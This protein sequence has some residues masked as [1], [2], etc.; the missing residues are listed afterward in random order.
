MPAKAA[1]PHRGRR[2]DGRKTRLSECV[3]LIVQIGDHLSKQF[4]VS[5]LSGAPPFADMTVVRHYAVDCERMPRMNFVPEQVASALHQSWSSETARQWTEDNPAA[6]Q[7]NV[8]VL[9][10]HEL[11]GGE[12]LKTRLPE[13]D[14]FYNRIDGVRF[15]FTASQFAH[16]ITYADLPT[17]RD[18]AERGATNA[19]LA[20]LRT[21]FLRYASASDQG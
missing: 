10:V 18:D 19:E 21:A 11:F 8:T 3:A 6:G 12:L 17:T 7:C 4:D 16:P 9:L 20:A 2:G 5:R 1:I 13:G 15:D 14:H